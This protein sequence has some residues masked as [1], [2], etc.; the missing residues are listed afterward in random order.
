LDAAYKYQNLLACHNSV[1]LHKKELCLFW[2]IRE[3]SGL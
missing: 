2:V 1:G 3:E